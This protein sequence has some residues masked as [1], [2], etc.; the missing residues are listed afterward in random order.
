MVSL[1][2]L[3]SGLAQTYDFFFPE[4]LPFLEKGIAQ[5]LEGLS[6]VALGQSRQEEDD[7][8]VMKHYS[9]ESSGLVFKQRSGIAFRCPFFKSWPEYFQFQRRKLYFSLT[10]A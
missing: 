7:I 10:G 3:Y 2:S 1:N 8:P 6:S 9:K 5:F 4:E